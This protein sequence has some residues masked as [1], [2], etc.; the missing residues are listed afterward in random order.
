MGTTL[1]TTVTRMAQDERRRYLLF[2]NLFFTW[3][4]VMTTMTQLRP[5]PAR[6]DVQAR[7]DYDYERSL[8]FTDFRDEWVE[9][10][11]DEI[12]NDPMVELSGMIVAYCDESTPSPISGKLMKNWSEFEIVMRRAA[13]E[14]PIL[15]H[16]LAN[17][18]YRQAE[19][20]FVAECLQQ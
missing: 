3:R 2:H 9:S 16:F 19:K 8:A 4:L 12:L 1:V 11:T 15:A 7:F 20:D 13:K 6:V 14:S 18:A 5:K 10:R 17:V